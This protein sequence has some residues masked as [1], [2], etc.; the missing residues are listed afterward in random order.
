MAISQKIA[1]LTALALKDKVLTIVEKQTIID[2]AVQEG[3]SREEITDYLDNALKEGLKKYAKEDLKHCPF[4]GAQIPLI[5]DNCLFCGN[6]LHNVDNQHVIKISGKEVEIIN[7]ENLNTANSQRNLKNCPD[8]GAPFPLIS[9]ICTNCGHVLHEQTD[10]ALNIKNLKTNIENSIEA[11]KAAP[12][13]TVWD[14]IKFRKAIVLFALAAVFIITGFSVSGIGTFAGGFIILSFI[15]L[16]LSFINLRKQKNENSPVKLSDD[17]FY[18][19]VYSQEMYASQIATLYGG[20]DEAEK[21]L[22]NLSSEINLLKQNRKKNRN[23]ISVCVLLLTI[24][25][26]ILPKFAPSAKTNYQKNKEQHK[27]IYEMSE[28]KK[29]LK[30]LPEYSVDENLSPY[31]DA[32][33]EAEL[34]FDVLSSK[35]FIQYSDGQRQFY[36]V[37]VNNVKLVSKGK[38]MENG[39][40]VNDLCI[41]LWNK[42]KEGLS[43]YYPMNLDFTDYY[44]GYEDN[45]YSF[46]ENAYES[47][48]GDFSSVD[49]SSNVESL[50]NIA[51]SA[52][53][54]TIYI[55]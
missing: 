51:D 17:E 22:E 7:R 49:S 45:I 6:S 44:K 32:V 28:I 43:A 46:V 10:S 48:Y 20:N 30:P 33:S 41:V 38:K 25:V 36:K 21:L 13:P 18:K 16:V 9:N 42:N 55:E 40:K 26:I 14:V 34:S 31:F 47:Y 24:C 52:Y 12:K 53:Y 35:T 4:C 11:I 1:Q 5:S 23:I 29:V 50:K 15:L 2:A 37:R 19:A 8:C 3:T 54:Y 27:E 39:A